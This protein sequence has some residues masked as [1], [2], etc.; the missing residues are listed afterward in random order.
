VQTDN[1]LQIIDSAVDW[2]T[3]TAKR[4]DAADALSALAHGLLHQSLGEG[5]FLQSFRANQYRGE[6]A[7]NV[8]HGR[9]Y[10]GTIVTLTSREAARSAVLLLKEDV[11][12][13][14]LD[15]QITC[16]D[17]SR[18]INRA[19]DYYRSMQMDNKRRGRPLSSELWLNSGGGKT[20]YMGSKHSDVIARLY[21]K[22]IE[23]KVA[24][25]GECWRYEVQYRRKPATHI[26]NAIRESQSVDDTIAAFVT[27]YF[28]DRGLPVP[29]TERDWA[30]LAI[31]LKDSL[32]SKD[33]SDEARKLRW[34]A[35]NVAKTVK[36]LVDSGKRDEVLRALGLLDDE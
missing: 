24:Q 15:L 35:A 14:R 26:T 9:R 12:V 7:G 33:N 4:G 13:T 8:T 32:Y 27:A 34:L 19:E 2:L 29:Q 28:S 5:N 16:S 36:R 22:G 20:L 6:R 3:V 10:D 23:S 25:A 1:A 18:Y 21:D 30:A 17:D 31:Q 11:H